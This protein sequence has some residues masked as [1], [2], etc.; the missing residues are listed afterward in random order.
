MNIGIIGKGFVGNAV[1]Q[2]FKHFYNV[3]SF[4]KTKSIKFLDYRNK[5]KCKVIF[6]C[7]PTP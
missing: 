6:I 2:M 4:D 1:Y 5:S 3:Y 7:V